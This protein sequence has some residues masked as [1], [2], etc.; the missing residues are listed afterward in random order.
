M[1][2]FVSMGE[3]LATLSSASQLRAFYLGSLP[4]W[5]VMRINE[6]NMEVC[7]HLVECLTDPATCSVLAWHLLSA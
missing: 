3:C 7:G 5:L 1:L 6:D 4:T 2:A